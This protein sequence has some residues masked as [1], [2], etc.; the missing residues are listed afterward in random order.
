VTLRIRVDLSYDG[1]AFSGWAAQPGR[2]TV[3]D[4]L[5]QALTTIVRSLTPVR[6]VVA[7][8]TDAGVHARGQVAHADVEAADWEKVRGRSDR[9]LEEAAATRL[10]GIL[11][12]DVTVRQVSVAPDGFDARFSALRRRYLY[13]ICDDPATLD[14][15]RRFDTVSVRGPLDVAAMDAAARSLLGLH[16][17]AAF[18][19]RR[20]GATT[21]R[22]LL[23]HRWERAADGTV[24]A[25]VVADAFCHS[26][27]RSLVGAVVPVGEGRLSVDVPRQVLL[28]GVRDSRVRVMP[29]HGLS[30]E[31]VTY[32]P[33]DELAARAEESRVRRVLPG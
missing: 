6:L 2:R 18:C 8:R 14:P 16:D 33:D 13:R 23:D 29:P 1:T 9:P 5:S 22:T 32:P 21:V 10:R 3:E 11:P 12:P 25:T 17:F 30:L 27:V 26:M 7:G 15:L 31:E 4:T 19:R 20:A 24:E 28:G